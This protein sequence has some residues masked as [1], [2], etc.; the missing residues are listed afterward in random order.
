MGTL[1]NAKVYIITPL[2]DKRQ[3]KAVFLS[4]YTDLYLVKYHKVFVTDCGKIFEHDKVLVANN[5]GEFPEPVKIDLSDLSNIISSKD[6][7]ISIPK[8]TNKSFILSHLK[9]K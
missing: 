9:K 4:H 7:F 3:Y 8:G 5:L 1:I 6:S 2:F